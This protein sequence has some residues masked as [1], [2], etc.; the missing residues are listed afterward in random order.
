MEIYYPETT[1]PSLAH[2]AK[3]FLLRAKFA[4]ERYVYAASFTNLESHC[5]N[6]VQ[7]GQPTKAVCELCAQTI[8]VCLS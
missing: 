1:S 5:E 6:R 7:Q 4:Y 3:A 2:I 8:V